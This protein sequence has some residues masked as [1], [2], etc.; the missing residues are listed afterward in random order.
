MLLLDDREIRTLAKYLNWAKPRRYLD[1]GK[2][3]EHNLNGWRLLVEFHVKQ[4]NKDDQ[5]KLF[6][7]LGGGER[8]GWAKG[9][10]RT[11][12]ARYTIL[13]PLERERREA[14]KKRTEAHALR[15]LQSLGLTSR[16]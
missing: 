7:A 15:Q 8:L 4:L 1:S 16:A 6:F 9:S 10:P 3:Y 5:D 13:G 11:F 12:R 2:L 14:E